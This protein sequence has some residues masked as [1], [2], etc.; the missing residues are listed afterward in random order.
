MKRTPT[1]RAK[2][3]LGAL[4]GALAFALAVCAGA[5]GAQ[6]KGETVRLQDYIG[7]SALPLHVAIVKGYCANNGIKCELR[8]VQTTALGIQ[9]LLA[10]NLDGAEAALESWI[11]AVVKGAKINAVV[12]ILSKN[13]GLMVVGNHVDTP[14]AGKPFPD[15]VK[16]LKGKKIGVTSR[17]SGVETGVRFMLDKA[18]M[19]ADDVTFVAVGTPNTA[20]AAL[21]NKQIDFAMSYEPMGALCDMTKQCKV[22]WRGDADKQP[23]E[24]YATNGG[25]AGVIMTQ[26]YIDANPHVV[27]ALIKSVSEADKFINDPA[28]FEEVLKIVDGYYKFDMPN[29][30]KLMRALLQRQIEHGIFDP[31][32]SRPAVKATIDYMLTTGQWDKGVEVS[33]IIDKRAP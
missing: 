24:I 17:G 25:G 33:H 11:P 26:A 15:W 20:Y 12:N 19:K 21:L 23:A 22:V 32:I 30:D 18:G 28:N 7:T 9:A 4:R 29:G 2:S 13:L 27:E 14:N 16:D 10:N 5:A 1:T 8:P 31:R 6:G 3:G